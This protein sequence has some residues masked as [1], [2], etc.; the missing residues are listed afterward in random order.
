MRTAIGDMNK[1]AESLD[2][3]R[4]MIWYWNSPSLTITFDDETLRGWQPVLDQQRRWWSDK[5]SGIKFTEQRPPEIIMQDASIVTSIQWMTVGSAAE[6]GKPARLVVTSVWKKLP[7]GWRIV[8]A[9]ES[10]VP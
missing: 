6:S 1:S 4:F 3:D 2:A 9:H 7:E 5:I 10:L 8:I